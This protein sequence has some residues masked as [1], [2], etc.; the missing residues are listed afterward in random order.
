MAVGIPECGRR[1]DLPIAN[2]ATRHTQ[3]AIAD[4][5][6]HERHTVEKTSEFA[7]LECWRQGEKSRRRVLTQVTTFSIAY[8]FS[9]I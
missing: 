4:Y 9:C 2:L 7:Y 3:W 1:R 8:D 6:E 5:G